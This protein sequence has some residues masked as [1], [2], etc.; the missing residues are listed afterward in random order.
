MTIGLLRSVPELRPASKRRAAYV[1]N[2]LAVAAVIL[3]AVI[4]PADAIIRFEGWIPRA[5][6]LPEIW[7]GLA[8]N[9]AVGAYIALGVTRLIRYLQ[10]GQQA[11]DRLNA[12]NDARASQ[13]NALSADNEARARQLNA[14]SAEN[15][16]R[17]QELDALNW[18]LTAAFK[19]TGREAPR[20]LN[21]A[22]PHAGQSR[23]NVVYLVGS[24]APWA[25][26][27]G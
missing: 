6:N 13:L 21:K 8:A 14:L 2:A 25:H 15:K 17:A 22:E 24:D 26:S 19:V 16:A 12:E 5:W 20:L 3:T 18:A 11:N 10:A 1:R 4:W 9:C 27:V 23:S 7:A